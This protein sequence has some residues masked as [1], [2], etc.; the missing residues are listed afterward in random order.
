M[1]RVITL[2]LLALLGAGLLAMAKPQTVGSNGSAQ[3]STRQAACDN[4]QFLAEENGFVRCENDKYTVSDCYDCEESVAGAWTCRARWTCGDQSSGADP[5]QLPT[6]WRNADEDTCYRLS[7]ADV[8]S[9]IEYVS[10]WR[11]NGD[12]MVTIRNN[13]G[14]RIYVSLRVE[15]PALGFDGIDRAGSGIAPGDAWRRRTFAAHKPTGRIHWRA[16]GALRG[17]MDWVCAGK[18]PWFNDPVEPSDWG[19]KKY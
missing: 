7:T 6:G 2:A 8:E 17:S 3:R 12:L 16:Y 11:Q 10:E 18:L 4:A 1:R 19:R 5:P 14:G 9:G 13:T 15:A